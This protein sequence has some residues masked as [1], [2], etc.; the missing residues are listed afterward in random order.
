MARITIAT[1]EGS[2]LARVRRLLEHKSQAEQLGQFIAGSA[3]F[4]LRVQLLQLADQELDAAEAPYKAFLA[5]YNLTTSD[6]AGLD[7]ATGL[8]TKEVEDDADGQPSNVD[9]A[10]PAVQSPERDGPAA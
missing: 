5:K 2:E 1:L 9:D 10:N 7:L 4:T 6:G 3:H 8:L